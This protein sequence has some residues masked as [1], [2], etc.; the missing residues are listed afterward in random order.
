MDLPMS[1]CLN[2]N[3][4]GDIPLGIFLCAWIN[5]SN[6]TRPRAADSHETFI[7]WGP[8]VINELPKTFLLCGSHGIKYS[9]KKCWWLAKLVLDFFKTLNLGNKS[10]IVG[11]FLQSPESLSLISI[12]NKLKVSAVYLPKGNVEEFWSMYRQTV[13][14]VQRCRCSSC[15]SPELSLNRVNA[16]HINKWTHTHL[17]ILSV[18]SNLLLYWCS[19]FRQ[20]IKKQPHK[21]IQAGHFT[22]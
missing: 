2:T 4:R 11:S 18:H 9:K 12:W 15:T 14:S 17:Y 1:L 5:V 7:M 3:V 8:Q 20:G 13:T 21:C 22:H 10:E 6:R 16:R 19:G